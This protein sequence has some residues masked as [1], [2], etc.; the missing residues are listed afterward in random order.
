MDILNKN[1]ELIIICEKKCKISFNLHLHVSILLQ[2]VFI[3]SLV[4]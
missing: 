3:T 1:L 4:S 2:Y